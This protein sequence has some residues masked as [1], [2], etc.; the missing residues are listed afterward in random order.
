MAEQFEFDSLSIRRPRTGAVFRF[1]SIP[2]EFTW[3]D[4][5]YE[6]PELG[7]QVGFNMQLITDTIAVDQNGRI[8]QARVVVG[9]VIEADSLKA[10]VQRAGSVTLSASDVDAIIKDL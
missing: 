10:A 1:N 9:A 8:E 5:L 6:N 4:A 2:R 3:C 7:L